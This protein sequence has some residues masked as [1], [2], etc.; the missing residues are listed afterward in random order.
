MESGGTSRLS[1]YI[2]RTRCLIS[3]TEQ[4]N[5]M[6]AESCLQLPDPAHPPPR[7]I[8]L[9]MCKFHL[10]FPSFLPPSL[11]PFTHTRTHKSFRNGL[12]AYP[13]SSGGGAGVE[14]AAAGD[15]EVEVAVVG[16]HAQGGGTAG[17]DGA[18]GGQEGGACNKGIG[19]CRRNGDESQG[20]HIKHS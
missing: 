11:P 9:T 15:A 8:S 4:R 10:S 14:D 1:G 18:G 3:R 17:R 20:T 6:S 2:C 7:L 16:S 5:D 19:A 12:S 13:G